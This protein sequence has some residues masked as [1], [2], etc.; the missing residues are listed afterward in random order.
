MPVR[1]AVDLTGGRRPGRAAA[2]DSPLGMR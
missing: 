1:V 2:A